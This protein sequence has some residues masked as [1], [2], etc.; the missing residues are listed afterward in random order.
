MSGSDV[1]LLQQA[2]TNSGLNNGNVASSVTSSIPLSQ[3]V[4]ASDRMNKGAAALAEMSSFS[5]PSSLASSRP[6][7]LSFLSTMAVHDSV[8]GMIRRHPVRKVVFCVSSSC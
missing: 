8:T 4:S 2:L 7:R 1:D 6:T 3:S 5:D